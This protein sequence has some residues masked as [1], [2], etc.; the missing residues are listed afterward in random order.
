MSND[1]NRKAT[2]IDPGWRDTS[3]SARKATEIDE[4]WRTN[5]IFEGY[6]ETQDEFKDAIAK[7][8]ELKSGTG[9]T[10][11]VKTTI[12]KAGGESIILLCTDPGGEEVVAKVYYEPV[13]SLESAISSRA[14]V[15]EYMKTEEGKRY[16]LAVT[17]YGVF[18]F[19]ESKYYFEVMPYCESADISNGKHYSFEQLVDIT[20]QLND[21]LHSIHNAGIIHRDIKPENL[22]EIDGQIKIGDFGI[23][24]NGAQG[25]SV[26]TSHIVGSVGYASPETSRY[27]NNEKSDYYS[28]GVTLATLYEGH[29][30]FENMTFEM[31]SLAQESERLPLTRNDPNREQLENLLNGLCRVDLKRRFGY[32]DVKCWLADHNYTGGEADEVW[33]KAFRLFNE[34][35]RDEKSLFYG[36]TKDQEHWEEAKKMLYS[37]II[38]QF[39]MSFRTDL[40]RTAQIVDEQYRATNPDKG[41][42]VFLKRLFAP[43]PIVWRGYTFNGLSEL[44]NKMVA[45]KKPSVYSE[46]LKNQCIS[47]WLKNT[48][49]ITVD[50]RTV[51]LVDSIES[52]SAAEPEV[53]CYWFG[54]SFA[55]KRMLKICD[56]TVSSINEMIDALF[57]VPNDFYQL[58]GYEK[59]ISKL[60]GADLYGF[61]YSFGYKEIVEK[62]WGCIGSCDKFNKVTV[63]MSMLDDIAI[64]SKANPDIIRHFFVN[65]GPVGLYAYV[66]AQVK[67][68]VYVAMDADGQRVLDKI[69][70]FKA[71][72]SGNVNQL[73]SAYAPLI[74]AEEE[75]RC[76][77][78]DNPYC[79]ISGVY[80]S[81]GIL[82]T[83]LAGCYAFKIF[84]RK[85]PLGFCAWIE[86]AKGG[87]KL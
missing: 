23:A 48:E 61:L 81:Q 63:L 43:G 69:M 33:P 29:F 18:N 56:H 27:I 79:I 64:K 73:L 9:N 77:L 7:L 40:A 45:T 24:K 68:S 34:V 87:M 78:I 42:S 31:Q 50:D 55:P 28:L 65:Y 12:S 82:C 49:G 17:D 66:R 8:V 62:V 20:R 58:D 11:K 51:Q 76:I 22:Y 5:R 86:S 83:N 39:F 16:T 85:A 72:L 6:Y 60:D 80:E 21:A 47:H 67:E 26:V 14:A 44:G 71:P 30:V 59:L 57:K 4:G 38:E 84:D 35:Y 41:L 54:N 75:M 3:V 53:A 1:N 10:Y 52:L 70:N 13:I 19:G 25:R 15:L 2:Q 32:E 46:L 37:K 36:I 74:D